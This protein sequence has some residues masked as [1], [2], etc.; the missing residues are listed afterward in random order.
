MNMKN[1]RYKV[2][3]I[4]MCLALL[5]QLAACGK[6]DAPEAQNI[7]GDTSSAF[8]EAI[9][10]IRQ[11]DD[12][13][14]HI[15][16]APE[17]LG[18]V[19][20]TILDSSTVKAHINSPEILALAVDLSQI[21]IKLYPDEEA[22]EQFEGAFAFKMDF[23]EPS[24]GEVT[25]N[26]YPQTCRIEQD[27]GYNT[28]YDEEIPLPNGG[29][30]TGAAVVEDTMITFVVNHSGLGD[31]VKTNPYYS[32]IVD[33][34]EYSR[35]RIDK[36]V[37]PPKVVPDLSQTSLAGAVDLNYFADIYP[38]YF[39]ME[40]DFDK[41]MS[42]S[43]HAFM[44]GV[45]RYEGQI[46][47]AANGN[48]ELTKK[49][50]LIGSLDEFGVANYYMAMV[51]DSHADLMRD[52]VADGEVNLTAG[53]GVSD[54]SNAE[55]KDEM[56][57][58]FLPEGSYDMNGSWSYSMAENVLY[59]HFSSDFDHHYKLAEGFDVPNI[60]FEYGGFVSGG[61]DSGIMTAIN[62]VIDK[63]S[64]EGKFDYD[65]FWDDRSQTAAN[66]TPGTGTVRYKGYRLK[67]KDASTAEAD[68]AI[69]TDNDKIL[70]EKQKIRKQ[71]DDIAQAKTDA[72]L[73]S[74]REIDP[75]AQCYIYD[76][77]SADFMLAKL[78]MEMLTSGGMY[79][80]DCGDY[81]IRVTA[82]TEDD[83]K[84]VLGRYNGDKFEEVAKEQ[85]YRDLNSG[86]PNFIHLNVYLGDIDGVTWQQLAGGSFP[87]YEAESTDTGK[88]MRVEI[89]DSVSVERY[90]QP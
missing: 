8:G 49:A 9:N 20:F 18:G 71:L 67:D 90:D 19:S 33:Y 34:K 83:P 13:G 16:A 23:H 51:Y 66:D 39:V 85:A 4:I 1:N 60:R 37:S 50:L 53:Y 26:V 63:G 69:E 65:Y 45:G 25:C 78:D 44:Q 35:G 7:G 38:E 81:S 82:K 73:G 54:I 61:L 17:K 76:A 12:L 84:C 24:K 28:I 88:T 47:W 79:E 31:I 57:M 11:D 46:F 2:S 21:Q 30:V 89:T 56:L 72:I 6:S 40:L 41:Y 22:R 58:G 75:Q 77:D 10:E 64:T 42:Y 32:V 80:I 62:E 43:D 48:S 70:K 59:W 86:M 5:I 68:A 3:A 55:V 27:N 74:D 87:F 36:V 15:S 29:Y 52:Y 14:N